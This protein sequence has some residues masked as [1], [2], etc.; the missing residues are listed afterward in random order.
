MKY[1][2][3]SSGLRGCYLPDDSAAYAFRTRREL[4]AF[5]QYEADTMRE[6]YGFGGAKREVATVAAWMWS[7]NYRHR[8]AIPFGRERKHYPFALFI[9]PAT[10]EEFETLGVLS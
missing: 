2:F 7:G 8:L 9:E 4:K 6:A 1:F 10:K 3:I 5:L